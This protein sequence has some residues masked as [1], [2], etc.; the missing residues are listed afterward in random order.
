[1]LPTYLCGIVR[2]RLSMRRWIY[3]PQTL[4]ETMGNPRW[5]AA[6]DT[7]LRTAKELARAFPTKMT[8]MACQ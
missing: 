1:M 6:P 4:L 3:V 8:M 2:H 7:E 5:L